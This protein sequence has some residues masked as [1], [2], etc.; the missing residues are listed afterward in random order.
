M[1]P[2][3]TAMTLQKEPGAV[4]IRRPSAVNIETLLMAALEK[5]PDVVE[6][7]MVVRRELN[8]ET[9]KADYDSAVAKFQQGCPVLPKGKIVRNDSGTTLYS[10][11]PF[12][13]ILGLV[14]PAMRVNGLSF[15]LDTDTESKDGWVIA[16]C[17]IT[18]TS[19][20]SE[21]SKAK[22]PLGGGTKAMS[23]TQIYAAALS[24]A[25]RRVFCNALGLVTGGEDF[26][27]SDKRERQH[28]PSNKP[29][30]A[31][32]PAREAAKR[33]WILLRPVRGT[34][35]NWDTSE[36]WLRRYKIIKD[37]ETV[38]TMTAEAIE[39]AYNKSSIQLG[40]L[41]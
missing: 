37:G 41:Q 40:D 18:H 9:A 2:E 4:D 20:H 23:S 14:R 38:S 22:F 10:Y 5:G 8:A 21:T 12:E 25:S 6:R 13:T 17:K 11:C 29:Q 15:S 26:D 34:A 1:K 30:D 16:T 3:Q 33:L 19:G 7:M 36:T 35:N 28:S 32:S 31:T 27:G 24:F 39:E